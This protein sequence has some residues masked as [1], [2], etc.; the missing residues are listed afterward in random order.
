MARRHRPI[1]M[2]LCFETCKQC[3]QQHSAQRSKVLTSRNVCQC[4]HRTPFRNFHH[5]GAPAYV[6][7]N[8][9]QQGQKAKKWEQ[10]ERI[11]VYSGQ[12]MQYAHTIMLVLSLQSGN[13]SPQYHC[14]IDDS[15][16]S[17]MEKNASL[18]PASTW[19]YK[20]ELK[21]TCMK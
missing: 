19:Q 10:R 2:A 5:F 1:F 8:N 15:F 11:G 13:F 12:S 4:F 21:S 7:N 16:A 18:V 3:T 14:Q 6:F 17:V 20:A 9:S